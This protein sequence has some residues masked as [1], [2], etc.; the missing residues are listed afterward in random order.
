MKK[1]PLILL[2]CFPCV[3]FAQ[4]E[5]V[6]N[7]SHYAFLHRPYGQFAAQGYM[8]LK[9]AAA[10]DAAFAFPLAESEVL[11][12]QFSNLFFA[13][14]RQ[15]EASVSFARHYAR[16][17]SFAMGCSYVSL[18]FSDAYYGRKQGL[19]VSFASSF[20]VK[21]SCCI[22]LLWKNP[23]GFPYFVEGEQRER[24]PSGLHLSG[25]YRCSDGVLAYGDYAQDF[26][27]SAHLTLGVDVSPLNGLRLFTALRFPDVQLTLG[28][29]CDGKRFRYAV[30]CAYSRPLGM[31]IGL[32]LGTSGISTSEI[33][34]Q[35]E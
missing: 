6:W 31:T 7:P 18:G 4:V 3:L 26:C 15:T 22:G 30:R 16:R 27:G 34:G 10:V 8:A 24:I 29:G 2:V 5:S 9:E 13:G 35:D 25:M 12:A 23:F 21:E 19:A 28:A 14:F 1:S 11:S 33:F 20:R 17:L 32:L